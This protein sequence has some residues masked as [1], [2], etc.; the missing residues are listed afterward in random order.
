M[1]ALAQDDK[2]NV[3]KKLKGSNNSL[4]TFHLFLLCPKCL[5]LKVE[6]LQPGLLKKHCGNA[7]GCSKRCLMYKGWPSRNLYSVNDR[8]KKTPHVCKW[9]SLSLH[10]VEKKICMPRNVCLVSR[11]ALHKAQAGPVS[12]PSGPDKSFA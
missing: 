1:F 2:E 12:R 7:E 8:I 6:F 5:D 3:G 4:L 11:F 9:E 10:A